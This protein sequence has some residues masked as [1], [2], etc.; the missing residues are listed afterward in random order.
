M[1]KLTTFLALLAGLFMSSSAMAGVDYLVSNPVEVT[2][3]STLS[4]DSYYVLQHVGQGIYT[5]NDGSSVVATTNLDYSCVLHLLYNSDSGILNIQQVATETYY[6]SLAANKQVTLGETKVDYTVENPS[7]GIF[8][9][10]NSE[11]YLHR[12]SNTSANP[13][14]AALQY[15]G[16]NSKWKIYKVEVEEIE[17]PDISAPKQITDLTELSDDAYYVLKN[18]GS[19]KYICATLGQYDFG[20]KNAPDYTCVVRL[21]Y[22]KDTEVLHIQQVCTDTYYQTLTTDALTLG[23]VPADYTFNTS[24][25][26]TNCFRIANGNIYLNRD[27]YDVYAKGFTGTGAWSQWE[28]YEVN[29]VVLTL[30]E[31][32]DMAATINL[33]NGLDTKSSEGK[34]LAVVVNLLRKTVEGY[35]TVV[36]PFDL[37]A[38]QVK[39]MF[40]EDAVVYAF[41]DEKEE[42]GI[43]VSFTST[44]AGIKANVPV[45]VKTTK[46]AP[47]S[48]ILKN[49]T[50]ESTERPVAEGDYFIGGGALYK[51]EGN[52]SIKPFRAYLQVKD[53]AAEVKLF[54]D[55][56]ATGIESINGTA[57]AEDGHIYSLAGQRVGKAQKG[58][59]IVNGKKVV[60]K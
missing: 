5:S 24:G 27:D 8:R 28:I 22:N 12:N 15:N 59:Y 53:E 47:S 19:N 2:D 51:S 14:G 29:D 52:T 57:K 26:N 3:L 35:N 4:D 56:M 44:T 17:R 55:G 58:I 25:V 37:S 23:D 21:L 20:F 54:I 31:S 60:V 41:S 18:H 1:K 16:D 43:T 40:G 32:T 11:C 13:I 42:E 33:C 49:I 30:D 10:V 48:Q 9:F 6:Q 36:L 50:I 38:E 45:L 39:E 46:A 7:D 34:G